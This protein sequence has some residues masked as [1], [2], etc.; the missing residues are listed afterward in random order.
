MF[1]NASLVRVLRSHVPT[2][3]ER[4]TF[5]EARLLQ[6][7]LRAALRRNAVGTSRTANLSA[8][9]QRQRAAGFA[10]DL[11]WW[12]AD[13]REAITAACRWSAR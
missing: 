12:L 6:R 9:L 5:N 4:A 10:P 3:A 1:T 2:D 8:R 13:Y 11:R 7:R